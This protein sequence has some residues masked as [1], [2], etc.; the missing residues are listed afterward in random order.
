MFLGLNWGKTDRIH[1]NCALGALFTLTD[2][3]CWK[4]V[5]TINVMVLLAHTVHY[6]TR[7]KIMPITLS[8]WSLSLLCA[9]VEW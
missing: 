9:L 1:P 7:T 8:E 2:L 6:K 3:L 4:R 5:Q